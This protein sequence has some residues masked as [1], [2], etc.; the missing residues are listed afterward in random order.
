MLFI[1]TSAKESININNAFVKLTENIYQ[2]INDNKIILTNTMQ[3][4]KIGTYKSNSN[5]HNL[6]NEKCINC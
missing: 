6:N 3:G 4:I 1:E 5:L 2:N